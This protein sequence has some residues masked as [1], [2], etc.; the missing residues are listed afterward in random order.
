MKALTTITS[1]QDSCHPHFPQP[2]QRSVH[3]HSNHM[4]FFTYHPKRGKK[5]SVPT[6]TTAPSCLP[7]SLALACTPTHRTPPHYLP[8][9]RVNPRNTNILPLSSISTCSATR[10]KS[11]SARLDTTPSHTFTHRLQHASP[12]GHWSSHSDPIPFRCEGAS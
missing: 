10:S 5:T 3:T 6:T 9:E 8:E 11:T 1:K 12:S 2:T 4:D 7:P